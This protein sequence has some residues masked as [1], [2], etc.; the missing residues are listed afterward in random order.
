MGNWSDPKVI[1]AIY[2]AI[3]STIS[4]IWN[5]VVLVNKSKRILSLK[6]NFNLSFINSM[7]GSSPVFGLL[8]VEMINIGNSD[9]NIKSTVL[10]FCGKKISMMGIQA[11]SIE[12]KDLQNPNKYPKFLKRGD[13]FKD[14]MDTKSIIKSISNQLKP[15]DKLRIIVKDTL[16]KEYKSVKFTYQQILD[17]EKQ[18][19]DYNAQH[20]NE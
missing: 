1:V 4:L 12:C 17:C 10:N 15:K 11:D 13:I 18:S 14:D 19:N 2:A 3:V 20:E 7:L 5:I 16:G 6:Y 8:S 9:I